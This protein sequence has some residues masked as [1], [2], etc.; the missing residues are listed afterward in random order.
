[1]RNDPRAPL[2]L[3]YHPNANG[4]SQGQVEPHLLSTMLLTP[5]ADQ[6][7]R[8]PFT[9][10]MWIIACL[11]DRFTHNLNSPPTAAQ[12][13]RWRPP[14]DSTTLFQCY[15]SCLQTTILTMNRIEDNRLRPTTATHTTIARPTIHVHAK[16]S[17]SHVCNPTSAAYVCPCF[18]Q[19]KKGW[20]IVPLL[21]PSLAHP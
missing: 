3:G 12:T 2:S 13:H 16:R 17:V 4:T 8:G 10:T 20:L 9:P 7:P 21:V 19:I 18:R 14:V 15:I 11:P 1:M 6:C 5:S